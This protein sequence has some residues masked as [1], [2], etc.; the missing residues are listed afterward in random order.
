MKP[1]KVEKVWAG[2]ESLSSQFASPVLKGEYLYGFHG[3][4]DGAK[5]EFRC[6]EAKSGKVLW[7][8]KRLGPGS[9]LVVGDE[10]LVLLESGEV[11]VAPAVPKGFQPR[12]R[13]QALGNGARAI[14]AFSGGR[15]F[16]RDKGQLV[17]LD[18]GK[19]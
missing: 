18:F 19:K 2:D 5:P 12:V 16:A 13:F 6:V 8:E 3:R 15:L 10:L 9:V 14:P 11:I 1:D 17:C 4:V 7:E